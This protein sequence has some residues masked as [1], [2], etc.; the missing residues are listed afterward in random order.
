MRVRPSED[1]YASPTI[2]SSAAACG[3][4]PILTKRLFN[5]L[6]LGVES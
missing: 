4:D 3:G 5:M 2:T 6:D 1:R